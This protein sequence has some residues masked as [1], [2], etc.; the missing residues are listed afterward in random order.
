MATQASATAYDRFICSLQDHAKLGVYRI[1]LDNIEHPR[2]P[3]NRFPNVS[4]L[5]KTF[6][7]QKCLRHN[8]QNY[9]TATIS[10]DIFAHRSSVKQASDGVN[11]L[12][13]RAEDK[14]YCMHGS[15]RIQAAKTVLRDGDRWWTVTLYKENIG[16]IPR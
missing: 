7:V 3:Q 2:I 6:L 16:E 14:V 8:P 5:K 11:E 12:L 1:R 13:L 9:I 15:C 4:R 10:H